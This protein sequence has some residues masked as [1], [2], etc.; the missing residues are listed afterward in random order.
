LTRDRD[1]VFPGPGDCVPVLDFDKAFDSPIRYQGPPIVVHLS[2]GR[3]RVDVCGF[4]QNSGYSASFQI[5]SG[6]DG[7]TISPGCLAAS[8]ISTRRAD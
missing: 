7:M 3:H 6:T 5:S 2:A 1:V 4:N 8:P